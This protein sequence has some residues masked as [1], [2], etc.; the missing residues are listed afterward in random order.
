[1]GIFDR[2]R[3]KRPL[4]PGEIRKS[5]GVFEVGAKRK[6]FL[7]KASETTGLE[8]RLE[9]LRRIKAESAIPG[10]TLSEEERRKA[11]EVIQ[12]GLAE[13]SK[14]TDEILKQGKELFN[15][16][17]IIISGSK[18]SE[19]AIRKLEKEGVLFLSAAEETQT[20]IEAMKMGI[21]KLLIEEKDVEVKKK[22]ED[23]LKKIEEIEKEGRRLR[24]DLKERIKRE[25][26][27]KK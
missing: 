7:E 22:A 27:Q 10:L 20:A 5:V 23:L 6:V 26:L 12:K 3:G 8:K 9:E 25:I 2:L 13:W 21:E 4:V 18:A 14:K 19:E 11:F 1:M 15:K 24:E 16:K 17:P